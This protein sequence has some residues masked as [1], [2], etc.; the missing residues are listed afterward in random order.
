MVYRLKSIALKFT[1][2]VFFFLHGMIVPS[3]V[4][5]V[6]PGPG[7]IPRSRSYQGTDVSM[8]LFRP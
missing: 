7:L 6:I 4:S 1:G 2:V 5:L 8:V 3:P